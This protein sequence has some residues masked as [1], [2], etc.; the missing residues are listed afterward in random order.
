[1]LVQDLLYPTVI[2]AFL[3][4]DLWFL[5]SIIVQLLFAEVRGAGG[6]LRGLR[7]R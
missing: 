1:M 5:G 4:L 2:P 7:G 6:E 3:G